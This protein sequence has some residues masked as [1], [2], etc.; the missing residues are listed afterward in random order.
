[1]S[2]AA[3]DGG[4][5]GLWAVDEKDA[6]LQINLDWSIAAQ[7]A[8]TT[9]LT[10]NDHV[11]GKGSPEESTWLRLLRE[12]TLLPQEFRSFGSDPGLGASRFKFRPATFRGFDTADAPPEDFIGIDVYNL[13][14][15]V[16]DEDVK[17]LRGA[18]DHL[19]ERVN[20][21]AYQHPPVPVVRPTP[22]EDIREFLVAGRRLEAMKR[23]REA[24][25]EAS[26][27]AAKR[28]IEEFKT[29]GNGPK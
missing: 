29:H 11:I 17:S 28:A 26:P 19:I 2:W 25:P 24:H 16:E 5:I 7:Q 9:S 10:V 8:G 18:V 27:E 21:E 15:E 23:Y 6:E 13:D 3:F 14:L 1:M 4:S 20:S 12:A 22:E